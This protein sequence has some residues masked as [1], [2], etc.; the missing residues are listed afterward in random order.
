MELHTNGMIHQQTDFIMYYQTIIIKWSKL[1]SKSAHG[2]AQ[3]T[4]PSIANMGNPGKSFQWQKPLVICYWMNCIPFCSLPMAGHADDAP[5]NPINP[6]TV[7]VAV[8]PSTPP[9]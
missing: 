5:F 8:T 6:D 1:T 2:H 7:F 4:S 9:K 3:R